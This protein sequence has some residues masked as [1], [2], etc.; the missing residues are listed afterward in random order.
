MNRN[1]NYKVLAISVVAA[2]VI[3]GYILMESSK[4]EQA[5]E[6]HQSFAAELATPER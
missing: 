5:A 6:A 2:A 3:F 1:V 4:L